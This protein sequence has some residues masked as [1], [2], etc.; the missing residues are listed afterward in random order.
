MKGKDR[1]ATP[2]HAEV[3]RV[4]GHRPFRTNLVR[5][6]RSAP[7]RAVDDSEA[8]IFTGSAVQHRFS[9]DLWS[10]GRKPGRVGDAQQSV[11]DVDG[12]CG[13]SSSW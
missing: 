12:E 11:G 8:S 7:I 4:R 1:S 6:T 2:T 13:E 5:K 10:K 9:K 3:R